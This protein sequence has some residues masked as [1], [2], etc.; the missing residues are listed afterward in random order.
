MDTALQAEERGLISSGKP[1]KHPS[2]AEAHIDLIALAARLKS[3][4]NKKQ[5]CKFNKTKTTPQMPVSSISG[6]KHRWR[7]VTKQKIFRSL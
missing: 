2:G 6:R 1:E 7:T 5:K 4:P 3:C